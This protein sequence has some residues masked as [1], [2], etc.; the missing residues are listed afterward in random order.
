MNWE[1]QKWMDKDMENNKELYE[2]FASTPE[3]EEWHYLNFVITVGQM[4]KSHITTTG[5]RTVECVQ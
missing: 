5:C 4:Y 1:A 2:A 3:D